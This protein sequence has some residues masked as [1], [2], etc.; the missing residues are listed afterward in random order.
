MLFILIFCFSCSQ[1][2]SDPTDSLE[3]HFYNPFQIGNNLD[4]DCIKDA[5]YISFPEGKKIGPIKICK[6]NGV[7]DIFFVRFKKNSKK[8]VCFF[9]V[10]E[11]SKNSSKK[12][13][14]VIPLKNKI[15]RIKANNFS[16]LFVVQDYKKSFKEISCCLNANDY[17]VTGKG[18]PFGHCTFENKVKICSD[19]LKNYQGHYIHRLKLIK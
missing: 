4:K 17:T 13:I 11:G 10:I 9:P 5:P 14:C 6:K 2:K 8:R 1:D 7:K 3:S 16:T 12:G 18:K 15:Y 19:F